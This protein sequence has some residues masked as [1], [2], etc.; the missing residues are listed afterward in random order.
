[1]RLVL[2]DANMLTCFSSRIINVG[3]YFLIFCVVLASW[4]IDPL[5]L[6]LSLS[7]VILA[8]SFAIGSASAK[9][10]EVREHELFH[11]PHFS[12]TNP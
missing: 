7:S 1:M 2:H 4:G 6:F 10:F 5:S 8:F 3:F 12:I 11:S 9:Y